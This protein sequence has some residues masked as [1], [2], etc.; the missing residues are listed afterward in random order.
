MDVFVVGENAVI[1]F[2]KPGE[3]YVSRILETWKSLLL[4]RSDNSAVRFRGGDS[5]LHDTDGVL[6]PE[7]LSR[8]IGLIPSSLPILR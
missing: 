5:E 6:A 8:R 7:P 3:L 2:V 1:V 4:F